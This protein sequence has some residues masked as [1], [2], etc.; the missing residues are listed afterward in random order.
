MVCEK[1]NCVAA[2]VQQKFNSSTKRRRLKVVEK[3][4]LVLICIIY[5][6]NDFIFDMIK[7]NDLKEK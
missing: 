1:R 6:F 2:I 3:I 7:N 4:I 5:R